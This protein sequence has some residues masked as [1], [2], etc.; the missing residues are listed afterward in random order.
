M[1]SVIAIGEALGDLVPNQDGMYELHP[2]GAVANVA[3][4]LSRWGI[5]C[6][7]VTRVGS[8]FVGDFLLEF[9]RRNGVDVRFV[10]RK[11]GART[12]LVFVSLDERGERDFTF[13]GRP[14]ADQFVSTRDV[15]TAY[16]RSCRVLHYGSISMMSPP[17]RSATLKAIRIARRLGR[18]VTYDANVRLNLWERRHGAARRQIRTLYRHADVVKLSV[19]ELRF[20][21]DASAES[22]RLTRIFA[23]QQVVFITGGQDGCHVRRGSFTTHVPARRVKAVDT[24]GAGDAFMAGVIHGIVTLGKR[25]DQVTV[26]DLIG[27][28]RFANEKGAAAVVRRG[29][30]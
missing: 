11:P 13:Y 5:G 3:V 18:I 28:A 30:V 23:P 29:A 1:P 27:I 4:N 24:T 14:S 10:R 8:D 26:D 21:F 6:G 16:I 7:L 25:F 15:T 2:G 9:L 20:L 12:G 19:E 22:P 17:S